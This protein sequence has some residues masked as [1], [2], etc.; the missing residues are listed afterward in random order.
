M[1]RNAV[2]TGANRGLGLELVK[3]VAS[4]HPTWTVLL[5]ART[6]AAA[7]SARTRSRRYR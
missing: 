4:R 6:A 1:S 3:R 2:V 5:A 7:D